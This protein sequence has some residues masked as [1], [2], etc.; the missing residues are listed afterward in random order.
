MENKHLIKINIILVYERPVVSRIRDR[1]KT[2]IIVLGKQ[3]ALTLWIVYQQIIIV[4]NNNI[5]VVSTM[6][7]SIFWGV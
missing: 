7:L 2:V 1:C 6:L 5:L 3:C 4:C